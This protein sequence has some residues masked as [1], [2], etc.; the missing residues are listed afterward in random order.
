MSFTPIL[1]SSY[2]SDRQDLCDALEALID[3]FIQQQS[4]TI[5][6]VFLMS[7]P[8][9]YMAE[10]PIIAIGDITEQVVHDAQ[11]RT[12]TFSGSLFYLDTFPDHAEYRARVNAFADKMRDL[13]TE[14]P[15][16]VNPDAGEL[17][18]QGFAE[19]ERTQGPFT[20]GAPHLDFVYRIQE[21]Y[22]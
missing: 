11:T 2:Q 9:N 18:E 16:I 6:R 10:G 21:G 19:D 3:A 4:Y 17:Y 7:M 13:F 20:F 5:G 1:P 15:R 14:N 12:T 8:D 22:R